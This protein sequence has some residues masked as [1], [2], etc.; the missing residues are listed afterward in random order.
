MVLINFTNV[1]TVVYTI[2]M[3]TKIQKWG[4]SLAVRL[5]KRI[6]EEQALTAGAGVSVEMEKGKIVIKP[7]KEK[8]TLDSLLA[9]VT[10]DNTHDETDWNEA[11]GKEVW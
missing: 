3:K 4:N 7:T 2:C 5:P 10:T 9:Q 1:D 11:R 8:E 6:T